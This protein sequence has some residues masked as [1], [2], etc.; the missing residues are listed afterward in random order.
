[1]LRAKTA[2][3][4]E[5]DPY[6]AGTE[7]A[8]QIRDI[9]PEVVF[10]FSSIHLGGASELSEAIYDTL[11][12]DRL[13]LIGTTG[14]GFLETNT[15]GDVGATI[16]A[17]N[18]SGKIGW[19]LAKA[20]NVAEDSAGAVMRGLAE[21]QGKIGDQDLQLLFLFSDFHSDG[22]AISETVSRQVRCPVVGGFAGDDYRMTRCFTLANR[23]VHQNSLVMLGLSG[24]FRFDIHV[25]QNL[26]PVGRPGRVTRAKDHRITMIEGIPAMDFLEQQTGK[27]L[28]D[29]DRGIVSLNVLGSDPGEPSCLRSIGSD[30]DFSDGGFSLFGCIDEGKWVQVC[31][32]Y[33]RDLVLGVEEIGRAVQAAG[34]SPDAGVIIT[35]AG[36]K[37]L[38]GKRGEQ[39]VAALRSEGTNPFPFAGFASFGEIGPVRQGKAYSQTLFHNMTFILVTLGGAS[40]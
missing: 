39:E 27:P 19:H 20:H 31:L 4:T 23:Q 24:N 16:L 17:L 21:I 22:R 28:T 26:T 14:D 13:I 25:A 10:L 18:G 9:D 37:R 6:R 36:R 8:T 12:N 34:F 1:M 29:L 5:V 30:W 7:L 33:P 40:T 35:C 38:L 3:T 2:C 11:G 15:V 32:A